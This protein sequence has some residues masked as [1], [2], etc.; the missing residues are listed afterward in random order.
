MKNQI[1]LI[2]VEDDLDEQQLLKEA[3]E[4]TDHFIVLNMAS[5]R[6]DLLKVLTV[7]IPDAILCAYHLPAENG[8]EILKELKNDNRYAN[9]PFIFVDN[10]Y[11]ET[12]RNAANALEPAGFLSRPV[13]A[14]GYQNF[15]TNL[16]DILK[17][18]KND[19]P[20]DEIK[21]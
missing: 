8:V 16:Y 20:I 5:H 7:T 6:N 18:L 12:Y 10:G 17:P 19:A 1:S 3:L 14:D 15:E 21:G 13:S 9:I 4:A 2:I 11:D